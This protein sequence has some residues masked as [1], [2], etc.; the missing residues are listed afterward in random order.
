MSDISFTSVLKPV[1]SSKF[2]K[3]TASFSQDGFVDYPWTISSSRIKPD[4]YTNHVCDC[5]V[6]LIT[7]GKKG[8]LMHLLPS[9]SGNH[10]EKRIFDFIDHN[11]NLENNN[12]L[13]AVLLG[14]HPYK[15][16]QNIFNYFKKILDKFKIP[17]TVLKTGNSPTDIA[18]KT[19]KDEIYISNKEITDA[20]R[21][22]K[23]NLEALNL[24]FKEVA[25]SPCDEVI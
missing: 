13:Q 16:S 10:D 4:V 6:C 7:D 18:Y 23:N 2:S 24:G 25:I 5:S 22:G 21:E 17:T 15:S 19:A 14:S 8:L 3:I 1:T 9:Y 12:H 20:L 11:F